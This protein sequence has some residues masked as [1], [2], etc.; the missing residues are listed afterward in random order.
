VMSC[1]VRSRWES[2]MVNPTKMTKPSTETYLTAW[3]AVAWAWTAD[4]GTG[5]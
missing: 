5:P 1:L 2:N 4:P 3:M